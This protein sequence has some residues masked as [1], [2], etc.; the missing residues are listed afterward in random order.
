MAILAAIDEN[1]RSRIVARIAADLA[2]TYDEDLVALHVLPEEDFDAHR[3]S[4][5]SIPEFQDY[6]VS[7]AT[8]DARRFASEFV[9][10]TVD[11]FDSNRL[12]ARGRIGDIAEEI[13]IEADALEPRF[14]IISGRRRSP[15]GKAVFGSTAQQVLLNADCP[16]MTQLSDR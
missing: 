16:V 5:Q 14:L 7:H 4:M 8:D 13:L 9:L 6:S 2:E 12:D 3:E 1:E 15:T 11:G 10:E